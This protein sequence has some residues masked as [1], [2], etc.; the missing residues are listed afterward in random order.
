M[1]INHVNDGKGPP[2]VLLHGFCETLHIWDD[3]I[4]KLAAKYSVWAIDLPGFGNSPSIS[5]LTIDLAA[6]QIQS[7][8]R[9]KNIESYT[10]I[11]HSLGGYVALALAEKYQQSLQG[12]VLLNSTCFADSPEKKEI[13]DKTIEFINRNGME[14]FAD[15]FVPNLFRQQANESMADKIQTVSNMVTQSSTDAVVSYTAAM[16]DRPDRSHILARTSRPILVLAG[17]EDIV[18]PRDANLEMQQLSELVTLEFLENTGHMGMYE[19]P[20]QSLDLL[21]TYLDIVTTK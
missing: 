2:V 18:V 15:N 16:R 19:N 9:D 4:E 10:A 5:P 17:E 13:R 7:F 3:L 20:D 14:A 21:Q 11:G 8:L 6:G 1:T 12:L